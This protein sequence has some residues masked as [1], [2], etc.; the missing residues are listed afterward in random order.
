MKKVAVYP[1]SF[2][3]IHPGHILV[4]QQAVQI[5]DK[6]VV[7]IAENPDKEYK[8][9]E[10]PHGVLI[11]KF[12]DN[13]EW[14]KKVKVDITPNSLIEY[15]EK[16]QISYVIR[17]L[18]NGIDLDYEKSQ[19]EYNKALET[20]LPDFNYI[21]FATPPQAEH[22]SSSKIRQFLKYAN[23]SQ[24]KKLYRIGGVS[25]TDNDVFDDLISLYKG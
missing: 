3:P 14:S 4:I 12:L 25:L 16:K 2:N 13:Y 5:F 6:V 18:R 7:L 10:I 22:L 11:K 19:F 21:Y 9:G 24:V 23:A 17:G 1:G 8:V 20:V 15:C